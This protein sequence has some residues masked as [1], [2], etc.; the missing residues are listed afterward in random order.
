MFVFDVFVDFIAIAKRLLAS[1]ASGFVWLET[2][3]H[4]RMVVIDWVNSATPPTTVF[5]VAIFL[6][7]PVS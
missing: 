7:V 3:P 4:H 2:S 1:I 6:Q 5:D